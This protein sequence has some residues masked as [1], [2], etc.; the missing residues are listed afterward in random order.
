MPR[1][2]RT[3]LFILTL[4]FSGAAWADNPYDWTQPPAEQQLALME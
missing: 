3:T 1:V 4:L 2:L